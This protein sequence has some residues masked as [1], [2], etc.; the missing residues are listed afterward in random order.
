MKRILIASIAAIAFAGTAAAQEAPVHYGDYGASVENS[1]NATSQTPNSQTHLLSTPPPI[2][3]SL[4]QTFSPSL[5]PA[6]ATALSS[7]TLVATPHRL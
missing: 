1:F 2:L 6:P 3:V 5:T 4:A 7:T